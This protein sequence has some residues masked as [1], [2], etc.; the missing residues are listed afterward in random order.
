MVKADKTRIM[1]VTYNN[2]THFGTLISKLIQEI[3]LNRALAV[4]N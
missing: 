1:C 4:Y 3:I 2:E